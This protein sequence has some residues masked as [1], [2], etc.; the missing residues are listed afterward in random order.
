MLRSWKDFTALGLSTIPHIRHMDRTIWMG[1]YVQYL[2][3]GQH[4]VRDILTVPAIG[5]DD[6]HIVLYSVWPY[7]GMYGT[8][9]AVHIKCKLLE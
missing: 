6:Y 2:S 8:Y 1:L 9:G 5:S 3:L 7:M 4:S